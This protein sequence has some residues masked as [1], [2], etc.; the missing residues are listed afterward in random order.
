MKNKVI[1]FKLL[2]AHDRLDATFWVEHD[3][4]NC[5]KCQAVLKK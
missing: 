4:D 5:S 2:S 1:P 3:I